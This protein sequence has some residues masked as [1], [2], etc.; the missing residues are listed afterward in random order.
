[1]VGVRGSQEASYS[2]SYSLIYSV[3]LWCYSL[4]Y[5]GDHTACPVQPRAPLVAMRTCIFLKRGMQKSLL[6]NK[7]DSVMVLLMANIAVVIFH[8]LANVTC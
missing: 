4:Q 5:P 8:F 6:G 3:V 1:V 2:S 7:M